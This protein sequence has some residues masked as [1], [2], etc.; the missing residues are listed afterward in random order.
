MV[1]MKDWLDQIEKRCNEE[2]LKDFCYRMIK[3]G[4]Y[5]EY[6]ESEDALVNVL[7]DM[8]FPQIDAMQEAY[9][10]KV[11]QAQKGGRPSKL[12]HKMVWNLAKQGY[13]GSDIAT[14]LGVPKTTIYS[15]PG[16]RK[17]DEDYYE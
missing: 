17:R 13:N 7:I 1:V 14:K 11:S 5:E 8:Y 9:E 3:Y 4:I 10:A 6:K 15:S 12:D 2:Q 16:W